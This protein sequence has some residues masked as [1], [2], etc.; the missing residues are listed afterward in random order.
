M[1]RFC[2]KF[3]GTKKG[4]AIKIGVI[5]FGDLGKRD[6]SAHRHPDLQDFSVLSEEEK[7]KDKNWT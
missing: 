7:D 4:D 1:G 5:G 6:D 2:Q 3:V